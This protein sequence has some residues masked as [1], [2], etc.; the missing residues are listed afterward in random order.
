MKKILFVALMFMSTASFS[1]GFQI[2]VKGGVNISNYTG[3][4]IQSDA[5]VGFHVGGLFNIMFTKAFSIQP[6]VLFSSQGAKYT[7]S[8]NKS[9]LK[10]SYINVPVMAKLNFGNV[11]LEAGPQVGFRA[12][13]NANNGNQTINNFAK[14]LD[15]SIGAGIGYHG[16]S[17]FGVGARYMAGLS[18][19]GDFN[20]TTANNIDPDFKNSVVQI[21][22]FYTLFNNKRK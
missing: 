10:V 4:N 1:Q 9:N 13:E 20:Q 12:G 21:S 2:G 6:E 5:L 19:V 8:G 22:V 14:N 17:G 15:L 16:Q 7:N 18:K 11:Y 3:G